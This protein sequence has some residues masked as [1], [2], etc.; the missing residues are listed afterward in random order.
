MKSRKLDKKKKERKQTK[1]T[2]HAKDVSQSPQEC[3]FANWY[4]HRL[5]LI[6]SLMTQMTI[7]DGGH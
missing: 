5:Q 6:W 2:F 1:L 3:A 4:L 7:D